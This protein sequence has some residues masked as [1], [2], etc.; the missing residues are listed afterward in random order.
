MYTAVESLKHHSV[1]QLQQADLWN[2]LSCPRLVLDGRGGPLG[3]GCAFQ[4]PEAH[5]G[6]S[7][8]AWQKYTLFSPNRIPI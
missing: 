3:R 4:P 6:H 2:V 8:R 5:P 7:F 1:H